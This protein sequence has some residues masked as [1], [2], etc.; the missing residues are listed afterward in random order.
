MR[1]LARSVFLTVMA[2]AAGT[3]PVLAAPSIQALALRDVDGRAVRPFDTSAGVV[4]FVFVRTD[5]PISNRYAPEVARLHHE[6]A[7]RNVAFHLV[8]PGAQS[9]VDIRRHWKAFGYPGQPLLDP[10]MRLVDSAGITVTPEAAI[11]D[12]T[13]SLVYHGRLD[14]RYVD[15]GTYRPEPATRDVRDVLAALVAGRRPPY[16]T[17]PAV[18]CFVEDLR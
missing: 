8:Y 10:A 11:Y 5:C 3:A 1:D 4:A 16:A 17:R 14:D 18:G 2:A 6:F 15:I 7:K 12:R 9:V 13:R